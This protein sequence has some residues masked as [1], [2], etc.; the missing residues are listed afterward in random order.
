MTKSIEKGNRILWVE[1]I[2]A[3]AL[4]WIFI[5]HLSERYFGYP[6]ISNPDIN[7]P[8]FSERLAQL[9]PLTTYGIWNIPANLLRYFGWFGD[10]GVQLFLI[11]SGFGL[12]WGLLSLH[13]SS[14][15]SYK[16]FLQKRAARLYPLW[17][18]VHLIFI[19]TWLL[20]GW[21]L[22]LVD[23]NLYLSLLGLRL[24][25]SSFY[26][27]S[28]AWWYFGLILQLYI[29]FPVLWEGLR[30]LGPSRLLILT[31]V[32]SFPIRAVGLFT[33]TEYL[34][35]WQRGGIFITRLPEFVFGMSFAAWLYQNPELLSQRLRSAKTVLLLIV[36]YAVGIVASLT[37]G[38]MIFA[39][40]V[41][42]VSLF[43]LLYLGLEKILPRLPAWLTEAGNWAGKH[44]YSMYLVHHPVILRLISMGALLT[45]STMVRS[46]AALFLTVVLALILEWGVTKV[47]ALI[48]RQIKN[49][50]LF[51]TALRIS[52]IGISFIALLILGELAVRRFAPQEIFGWGEK[53]SLEPD[54]QFGWRLAP[55][56]ETRLRWLSY[57]YVVDANALGFPD[58]EF[59]VEKPAGAYRIMVIGDAFSSAEGVDTD[60]AW[61]RLL[62]ADLGNNVEV[63]NFAI[64]GYGPSQYARVVEKFAP[65]YKPDL[66][67]VEVFVNDFFDVQTT[68][69]Q[70]QESIGFY[71]PDQTGLYSIVR[72]EHLRRFLRI[73]V[74]E[75]LGEMMLNKPRATGY[76][77]GNFASF[78]K[79]MEPTISAGTQQIAE[80]LAQIQNVADRN[81]SKLVVVMVPASIQVCKPERL[82]YYPRNIN[83]GDPE[84]YDP[85]LPQRSISQVTDE[86]GLPFFDL[87]DA[88]RNEQECPYQSR[89]MHWT[90]TGHQ[91]IADYVANILKQNKYIP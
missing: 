42:G 50:G 24:T 47:S 60:Q 52:V 57:D 30:R 77:L 21:G 3:I 1:F 8:P 34:D 35:L 65:I 40:F 9:I 89:N 26:Y 39:P 4:L 90:L 14:P 41:L 25:P 28:P 10:Q 27:F 19:A 20:T 36:A 53:V 55:S 86:L 67:I 13:V 59:T 29:V 6:F 54:D 68:D 74:A 11:M 82:K 66:I 84:K 49:A 31:I 46:F 70:F 78:E 37:L 22:S 73:D 79:G 23:K 69:Q 51:K 33:L 61:P 43:I 75:P 58:P 80:K 91:L 38:G 45:V 15:I 76:F 17:W 85:E 87:R 48:Q 16:E 44:S 2:K 72:L 83:F 32:V 63:L 81:N 18:G 71:Q 88:F 12:T 56:R 5:N 64:T 7:W 62:Q